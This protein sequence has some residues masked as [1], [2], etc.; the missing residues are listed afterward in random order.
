MGTKYSQLCLILLLIIATFSCQIS[1]YYHSDF[2]ILKRGA[3]EEVVEIFQEWKKKNG[4]VYRSDEESER[5][6]ENFKNNFKYVMMEKNILGNSEGTTVGLNRFADMSNEE[7]KNV[8]SSKIKIP[9]NKRKAID[10]MK[11]LQKKRGH[12]EAPPS[13]LDWRKRGAVT[14][15]KDQG[16]CGSCWAFS[17]TGAMEGVNALVTGDLISLSEQELISCDPSNYGCEGGYMDNAFEWVMHNGGI[18][19][20][21][22]YPYTGRDG[23]CNLKK[24]K[25][26]IAVTIDGYEDVA[27]QETALLCAVAKQPVS[28]GIQ[29]SSLDFQLYTGGIYDGHCSDNPNDIDHA[30]VIVGYG[31]KGG[32][33]Y[34]IIKNS[35][36]TAWGMEGYAFIRRNTNRRYGVCAI[37]A[38][39]SYP[40]KEPSAAPSPKPSPAAPP[41]PPP[42]RPP[43]PPP[44]P[45]RPPPP[46]TPT[47]CGAGLVCPPDNTCCCLFE[48]FGVCFIQ[49]CCGYKNG[50]CCGGSAYCC[51]SDYPICHV[52]EGL[53]LKKRGD[54]VGVAAKKRGMAKPNLPWNGLEFAAAAMR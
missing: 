49:G 37:N 27:E 26:E 19:S 44:P 45:P 41:P 9:F 31:S 48:F 32:K 51:P 10:E 4:K 24:V 8:Y 6:L 34:W 35:W 29:G 7:F 28:V 2:S 5:R 11:G 52:Y 20:S 54:H 15:V 30:V 12:C 40:T 36:G 38:L 1:C 3:E 21:S 47:F 25:D 23:K 22:D 18:D 33:D 42:H 43:P 17:A 16:D 14:H 13:S 39:A 50:V 53:C 46:P